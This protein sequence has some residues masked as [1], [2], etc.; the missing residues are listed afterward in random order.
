VLP[1]A[2]AKVFLNHLA[3]HPEKAQR[4]GVADDRFAGLFAQHGFLTWDGDWDNPIDCQHFE[5]GSRTDINELIKLLLDLTRA[6]FNQYASPCRQCAKS[7]IGGL[8]EVRV[9]CVEK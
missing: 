1:Q 5:I 8:S 6:S 4:A 7:E 2:R 3:I 9:C